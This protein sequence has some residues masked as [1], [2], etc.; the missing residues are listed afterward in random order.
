MEPTKHN[1]GSHS[2]IF[3]TIDKPGWSSTIYLCDGIKNNLL[4]SAEPCILGL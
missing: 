3:C 4:N 2:K 1:L